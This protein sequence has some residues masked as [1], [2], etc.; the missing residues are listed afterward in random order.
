M[1]IKDIIKNYAFQILTVI[2]IL[3]YLGKGC[4]SKKI[5]K[6]DKKLE[7]I[8]T[9]MI[10]SIDSLTNEI[11]MLKA[12]CINEKQAHNVMEK[13]MLDFLI[14]EDDLD[15]GKTSLSQIKNKIEEND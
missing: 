5:S 13:V 14:Y 9:G 10:H 15:K 1:K 3:L 12:N 6:V 4:T 2:F 8:N 11:I 7:S